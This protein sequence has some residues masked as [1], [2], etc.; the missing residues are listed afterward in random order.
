MEGPMF[1]IRG[2]SKVWEDSLR[3]FSKGG[4]WSN[5][6]FRKTKETQRDGMGSGKL[7]QN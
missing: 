4:T 6:C 7:L 5:L 1:L 3:D 2:P